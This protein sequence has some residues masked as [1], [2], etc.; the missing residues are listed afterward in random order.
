MDRLEHYRAALREVVS[1]LSEY[2]ISH[3]N[4]RTEAIIDPSGTIIS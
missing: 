2:P 1:E 3:G 4:V